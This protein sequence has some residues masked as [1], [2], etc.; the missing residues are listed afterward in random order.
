[1]ILLHTNH[2][3][4]RRAQ[5]NDLSAFLDNF[6]AALPQIDLLTGLRLEAHS[7]YASVFTGVP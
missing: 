5:G 4:E 6:L 3:E 2:T 7:S 1:M